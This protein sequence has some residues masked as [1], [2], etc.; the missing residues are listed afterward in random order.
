MTCAS[1]RFAGVLRFQRIRTEAV[2]RPAGGQPQA[3]AVAGVSL[4]G[5]VTVSQRL[6]GWPQLRE[7][8][9]ECSSGGH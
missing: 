4:Q 2:L 7:R 9:Q 3:S 6:R 8:G 1:I 5:H